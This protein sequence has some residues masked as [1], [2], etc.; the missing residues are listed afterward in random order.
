MTEQHE[1]GYHIIAGA[2]N[3]E[4]GEETIRKFYAEYRNEVYYC[5]SSYVL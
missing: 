3:V 1:K 5:A 4:D 2:Q